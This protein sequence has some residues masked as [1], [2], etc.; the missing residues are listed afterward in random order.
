[1]KDILQIFKRYLLGLV[2][3][4]FASLLISVVYIESTLPDVQTLKDVQL[5][6]PLRIY[7]ADKKLISE[8]GQKRRTPIKIEDVP[9]LLINAVIATED[10]RF[11]QHPGV[12]MRGILRAIV[13]LVSTGQK[14]QGGSTITMQVARNFFLTRQKTFARKFNEIL[15]AL[16]IEQQLSKTEIMELYLNKI[17]LGKRAYGVVAAAEVYYGTDVKSL[18]LAQIAMIAGLPQAPS[19]VNPINAPDSA[20]KRRNHVLLKMLEDKYITQEMYDEASSQPIVTTYH[21]RPIELDAPYVAEMVRQKLVESFGEEVYDSGYEVFTTVNSKEQ[22]AAIKALQ[23]ALTDYDQRHRYRGVTSKIKEE[24]NFDDPHQV[25]GHLQ[26]YKTLNNLTPALISNVQGNIIN[27]VTKDGKSTTIDLKDSIWFSNN[28][29]N[30]NQFKR[31]DVIYVEQTNDN[32]YVLSQIPEV[33]GAMVAIHPE[34]GKI[35]ALSGG[36][37]FEQSSFNRAT[38][39]ERQPGSAFKPFIYAAALENG[40]SAASIVN[41]A[42]I[43]E[44]D[45]IAEQ[46]WRPKN[47][48]AKFNGP[49]RLRVALTTS[50]NLVSIRLLKQLGIDKAI[51]FLTKAGF[52]KD[53][54]PNGLSLSLGTNHITPLE[55]AAA[56]CTFA[57]SGFKIEPYIIEKIVNYNGEEV[58]NAKHPIAAQDAPRAMSEETAYIITSI[59]QDVVSKG[60]SKR[61]ASLNRSDIAGKTGTTNDQHDAWFAGYNKEMVAVSWVGYD[62]PKSIKEYGVK[63]ALPMWIEFMKY[64]LENTQ[65]SPILQPNG[66][67]SV[68]IDPKNGLLAKP[69]QEDAIYE[70]FAKG[71]EPTSVSTDPDTG[72][73]YDDIENIF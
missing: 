25:Y 39:A 61:A 52:K 44:S 60:A 68:K 32:K 62:E 30:I 72:S 43:V 6:V 21:T 49:T 56:Y 50:K 7:S 11:Y 73:S 13:N 38:Q 18:N 59:L 46:D 10:R 5:Q 65:E 41:D 12:D 35:L 51:D 58:Y 53:S 14:E 27:A 4:T 55:L 70:L 16:K 29:L 42:P 15:L 22:H 63:A 23:H 40:F 48:N 31:K 20:L 24:I 3:F 36:F 2:I 47:D 28:N 66:I 9:P 8:F 71:T 45:P 1:M 69:D 17:Y 37:S 19:V 57:N 34:T 54:L 33:D 64:S 26:K 67:V